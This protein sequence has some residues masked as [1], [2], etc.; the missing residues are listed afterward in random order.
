VYQPTAPVVER[1]FGFAGPPAYDPRMELERAQV[2]HLLPGIRRGFVIS[3]VPIVVIAA[4]LWSEE[5][6]GTTAWVVVRSVVAAALWLW[7]RRL[8][9]GQVDPRRT[10]VA[11]TWVMALSSLGW[12]LLALMVD[13][14]GAEVQIIVVFALVANIAIV[15]A[16]CAAERR[17]FLASVVPVFV[18]GLLGLLLRR[19]DGPL[20]LP[21]L[22]CLA[23]PYSAAI[24]VT[25]HNTLVDGFE[26]EQR[27]AQLLDQLEQR[28]A[29]IAAT[30]DRLLTATAQQALL[31]DERA[32]LISS[33]GHDL[34]SPLG[35]AMLTAE[36][37]ADRPDAVGADMQ[38]ELAGRIRSQVHDAI[39]VLRDLTSSQRLDH[40]AIDA[41]LLELEL[42]SIVDDVIGRHRTGNP[43]I[44]NRVDG[45]IVVW[46]DP[47]LLER[48][49]DNL[50]G[51]AVKYTPA[52]GTILVGAHDGGAEVHVWVDDDGPGL[53]DDVRDTVFEP[54]VR[55]PSPSSTTGSG[56]GLYLVRSFVAHHGGRV[57][58]EPS[59]R[60]GSR[61]V[62][63]LPSRDADPNRGPRA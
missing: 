52:G 4:L 33:V 31:L 8:G 17:V 2:R 15:T 35:A 39:T 37:L 19:D 7:T 1:W 41:Q 56:V 3:A 60:G 43:T 18:V 50:V 44:E 12:G 58:W 30:N 61:F 21:M 34:G 46:A 28:Q 6:P 9:D 53:A 25:A 47:G 38:R 63:A 20:L 29:E 32:A 48:I 14:S 55:G 11:L 59:E 22:F 57:W 5:A 36:V 23:L 27:N 42:S 49:V 24:F 16:T 51:N 45:T 13:V 62:V 10:L 40:T 26:L 54:Y